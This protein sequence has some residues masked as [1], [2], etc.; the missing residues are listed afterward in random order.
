MQGESTLQLPEGAESSQKLKGIFGR[1]TIVEK[2]DIGSINRK[3]TA[4]LQKRNKTKQLDIIRKSKHAK[5]EEE[6]MQ[7]LKLVVLI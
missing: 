4:Q 1:P 3:K 7:T 6:M 5:T 2:N